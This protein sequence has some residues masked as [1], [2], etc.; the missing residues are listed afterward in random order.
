MKNCTEYQPARG[1]NC[2]SISNDQPESNGIK[3]TKERQ[4]EQD[5]KKLSANKTAKKDEM[6]GIEGTHV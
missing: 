6:T 5:V 1:R 3:A 2:S 4:R